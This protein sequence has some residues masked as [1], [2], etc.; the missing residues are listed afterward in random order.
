MMAAS[1][2]QWSGDANSVIS[3]DSVGSV[4]RRNGLNLKG[5][6]F[7][8]E[9]INDYE[10]GGH[11]PVHL[12]DC[13]CE[14]RYRVVHKLGNGGFANVWLCRDL[15]E[16]KSPTYVAMKILIASASDGERRESQTLELF[17]ERIK[18]D[19]KASHVCLPLH[20]FRIAGPN[21]SHVC[22]V[23]PVLGPRRV[24]NRRIVRQSRQ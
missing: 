20:E 15:L 21:G 23:F 22:L 17:R 4:G 3:L 7:G 24:A 2:D 18:S 11:H 1:D 5:P 6:P 16:R 8:L 19:I 9:G 13:L 14:E 12:G 10:A